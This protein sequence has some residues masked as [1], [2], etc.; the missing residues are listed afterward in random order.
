MIIQQGYTIL[1]KRISVLLLCLCTGFWR[2]SAQTA[3]VQLSE[4]A[5]CEG[6]SVT[7]TVLPSVPGTHLYQW[8]KYNGPTWDNISDG[9]GGGI[10][11]QVTA[12]ARTSGRYRCR[13][14]FSGGTPIVSDEATLTLQNKPFINGIYAPSVCDGGM[15]GA[16]SMDPVYSNGSD[17]REYEWKLGENV[18]GSGNITGNQ[19]P[20]LTPLPVNAV[21]HSGL[22]LQLTVTNKCG[23]YSVQTPITVRQI[24]APPT[25]GSG[26]R[27]YCQR[28]TAV[29]L[30]IS[31]SSNEAVWYTAASGG[32]G[33]LNAPLPDTSV[34]GTQRWWVSQ[35]VFYPNDLGTPTCESPRRE[36]SVL[37]RHLSTPPVSTAEIVLCIND[38]DIT[39]QAQGVNIQWYNDLK[40]TLSAAPQ[41]NTSESVPQVYYVTQTETGKCESPVDQ[42]K[43]TVTIRNKANVEDIIL[44]YNPDLCPE[45]STIIA[46]SSKAAYPTFRWYANEDKTGLFHTGTSYTTPVLS[47]DPAY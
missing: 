13:V 15:L 36:L 47:R 24:P 2:V 12:S 14:T 41:I 18:V 33:S 38:P 8:Q 21:T 27:D 10:S 46:V 45:S 44:S 32:D 35:K 4:P 1:L 31:E 22:M 39:L 17:L 19:I 37:V 11:Y 42:K 23:D 29:P 43:I 30:S 9:T 25:A 28:E 20:A 3:T 6:T 5:A 40:E 16:S 34:P 7:F 26:V